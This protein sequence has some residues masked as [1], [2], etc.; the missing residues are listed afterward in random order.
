[1]GYGREWIG[2]CAGTEEGGF[3]VGD[4]V[5]VGWDE[6]MKVSYDTHEGKLR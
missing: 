5:Y 4:G 2:M 6:D 3:V 1:M